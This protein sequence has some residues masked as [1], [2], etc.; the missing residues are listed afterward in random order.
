M[1]EKHNLKGPK[2]RNHISCAPM[3]YYFN[4]WFDW[5]R[6]KMAEEGNVK[7]HWQA[8]DSITASLISNEHDSG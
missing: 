1:Q 7:K 5:I 8:D 2:K 4:Y 3:S 6:V